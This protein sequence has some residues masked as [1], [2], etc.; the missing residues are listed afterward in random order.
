M[1]ADERRLGALHEAITSALLEACKG[2]VLPGYTDPETGEEVPDKVLPPSAAILAVGAKFLK[3]NQIT[4]VP[5]KDN[6]LGELEEI[7]KARQH[8]RANRGDFQA[9]TDQAGFLTG[10]N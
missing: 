6:Q 1:A 5:A 7:L 8:K 3:D 2:E 4:C 10:L 9:A